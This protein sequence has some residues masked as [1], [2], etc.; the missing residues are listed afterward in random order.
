MSR[1]SSVT[2]ILVVVGCLLAGA[3]PSSAQGPYYPPPA[4]NQK[5]PTNTRFVHVF[6][7]QV[8]ANNL[9]GPVARAVLDRETGLVWERSPSTDVNSWRDALRHCADTVH[10]NRMGWRLPTVDELTSLL[11]PSIASGIRLPAGHPFLNIS[12]AFYYWTATQSG[13]TI[14]DP[15]FGA[16]HYI[17]ALDSPGVG[18]QPDSNEYFAWCVRGGAK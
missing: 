18:S 10:G 14:S 1:S 15:A 6:F 5:L 3:S 13:I 4:W 8:C 7:E 9:C 11:D 16:Y 2:T 17:V 12:S